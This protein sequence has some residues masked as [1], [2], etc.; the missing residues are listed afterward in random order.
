MSNPF[1]TTISYNKFVPAHTP[2]S[3]SSAMQSEIYQKVCES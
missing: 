2:N 3:D 1:L